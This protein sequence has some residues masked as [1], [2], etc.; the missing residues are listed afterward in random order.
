[1]TF[2][3]WNIIEP[4]KPFVGLQNYKDMIHDEEFRRSVINTV[5]FTGAS[6][7]VS[8]DFRSCRF[9]LTIGRQDR[10]SQLV[11]ARIVN[12]GPEQ[13]QTEAVFRRL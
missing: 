7:P 8:S 1:M 9:M 2:H 10:V 6:V 5:Y 13:L 12:G 3:D 11:L 4:D